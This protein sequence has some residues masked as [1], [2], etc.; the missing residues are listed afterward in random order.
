MFHSIIV[1]KLIQ[2]FYMD[3]QWSMNTVGE[4]ARESLGTHSMTEPLP[5]QVK[6]VHFYSMTN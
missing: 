1:R 5:S 2:K 3:C 6:I 4:V